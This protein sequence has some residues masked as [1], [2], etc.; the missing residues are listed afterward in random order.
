MDYGR[1]SLFG[2]LLYL[3]VSDTLCELI[4][5]IIKTNIFCSHEFFYAVYPFC[6]S[7]LNCID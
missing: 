1:I 4:K 7:I 2:S 3:S 5:D 6:V